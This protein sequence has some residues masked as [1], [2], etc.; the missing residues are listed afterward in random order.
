MTKN[1]LKQNDATNGARFVVR[2]R[3][4]NSCHTVLV[5]SKLA[6][7]KEIAQAHKG[8]VA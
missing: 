7:S 8:G 3:T 2:M 5:T 6:A 1:K 4:S